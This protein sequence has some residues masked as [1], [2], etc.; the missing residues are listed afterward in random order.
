MPKISEMWDELKD[1]A[2]TQSFLTD[3]MTPDEFLRK[4]NQLECEYE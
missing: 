1:W 2:D 3:S 4:M